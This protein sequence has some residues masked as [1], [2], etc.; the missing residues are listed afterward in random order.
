MNTQRIRT[1]IV[2]DS[3]LVRKIVTASLEPFPEIE[4]VGTAVDPYDARDKILALNPD[5]ITLDI[6]MPKMDG[7]TFLKRIMQYRPM[8]VIIFSSHTQD[9]STKAIEALQAGAADVLG[10]PS[11]AHSAYSDGSILAERIILAA[12]TK[13]QRVS[14]DASSN[15]V[16]QRRSA[17]NRVVSG[18]RYAPRQ[19]I[20]MGASTGGTEALKTVL[21]G[22][23]SDMPAICIVQHIPAYFSAAFA[24]RLNDL[25][26]LEVREAKAGDHVQPGLVLVAP[27]GYHMVLKWKTTHYVVEL[28]EAPRVHYQRPAVD[29][30]FES[31]ARAGA[32]P[33][34][35][36]VLLT[37][38]GVDG[39]A[40]MLTLRQAGA[41][42]IAQDEKTS[43]VFGMPRAAIERGAAM[44]VTGLDQMASEIEKFASVV[45]LNH[46]AA[47]EGRY[48]STG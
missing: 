40:G 46:G 21:T 18:R 11:G 43:L 4:I 13:F 48:A 29:V 17:A 5:V 8:P 42:T 25:C 33:T 14:N 3:A 9:G 37:G 22:L 16:I 7:I 27:G 19:V 41:K 36:A 31:A 47:G 2:D 26:A 6:D 35:L 24:A 23:R 15:T 44:K 28:N 30:M 45:A 38:M 12:Q 39:A 32:G 10:K 34:C 1:L 20:L